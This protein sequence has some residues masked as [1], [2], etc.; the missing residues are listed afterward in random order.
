M[1]QAGLLACTAAVGGVTMGFEMVASRYLTPWFGGSLNT[2]AALISTVMTAMAV[3]YVWGGTAADRQPSATLAGAAVIA[4]G[5]WLAGIPLIA[6]P[7]MAAILEHVGD[8]GTGA[9][10]AAA[11]LTFAP[12]ALLAAA[13]PVAI[14]VLTTNAERSGRVAGAVYGA[15]TAG[16]IAGVL[17]TTFGLL[18]HIGSDGT[19]KLMAAILAITGIV[20]CI[21]PGAA[22]G[23]DSASESTLGT[24][25]SPAPGPAARTP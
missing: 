24:G 11:A 3:G 21:L 17:G 22:H 14:R 4:A 6:N 20:L 8:G 18:P 7:T 15:S 25:R 1:R 19:T 13:P 12:M 9:I 23:K 10:L 5:G 2:W 16:S